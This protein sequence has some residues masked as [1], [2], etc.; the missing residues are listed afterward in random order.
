MLKEKHILMTKHL[1]KAHYQD[2]VTTN[3]LLNLV[4]MMVTFIKHFNF[5]VKDPV[6]LFILTF[7]PETVLVKKPNVHL[8]QSIE[9]IKILIG[10]LTSN[11]YNLF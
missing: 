1:E 2:Q 6:I 4:N 9:Y 3:H 8:L 10:F 11:F 7:R 5:L